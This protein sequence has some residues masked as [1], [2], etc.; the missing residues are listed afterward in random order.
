MDNKTIAQA[1]NDIH[2]VW[3]RKWRDKPRDRHDPAWDTIVQEAGKIMDK[4]HHAPL[5][6]HMIRDLMDELEERSRNAEKN[7]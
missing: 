2:N 5:V 6:V 4:Y 1:F 3:W 7:R